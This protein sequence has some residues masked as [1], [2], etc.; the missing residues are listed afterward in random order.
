MATVTNTIKLPDGSTPDR[1]DVVIELVA[2]TTGRAAGW[3]T[4]SDVTIEATVRPTV[5]NGAWTA[6]LT[7]NA[8][9]TPSG[10]VYKVTEY[11]D[12]TR[13]THYIEV[14]ADGGSVLD[15][16]VDPPASVASAALTSHINDATDVH[17]ASAIGVLDA[18]GNYA[19][20]DVESVLAEIADNLDA[21]NADL[22]SHYAALVWRPSSAPMLFPVASSESP[23]VGA[24]ATSSAIGSAKQWRAVSPS[25]A[26]TGTALALPAHFTDR[27]GNGAWV[28]YGNS[29]PNYNYVTV[30]NV[31]DPVVGGY[32][33]LFSVEFET[34]ALQ[35]EFFV[36]G[37]S[38]KVWVW[39]DDRPLGGRTAT[40]TLTSSG[41]LAFLPLTFASRAR[42]RIRFESTGHLFGGVYTDPTATVQ[43]TSNFRPT[44]VMLGDSFT[45]SGGADV[46]ELSGLARTMGELLGWDVMPS[47]NG[48]TGY[49]NPGTG[50]RV[51]FRDRV[52]YDVIAKS[53]DIVVVAGGVND[54]SA[55]SAAAIGAEATA[56]FA[57]IAAGLPSAR[58]VVS[59]PF[60]RNGV[61]TIPYTL[62]DAKDAIYAAAA[63]MDAL[64]VDPI[65]IPL[66]AGQSLSST[67]SSATL[68]NATSF[69]SSADFPIG[70]TVEIG[71]STARERR[72]VTALSGVGPF[73]H[74]VAALNSAHPSGE[75]VRLVGPC[76]WT[77]TGKVGSTTGSGNSDRL[78]SSDGTHP[79]Q[80]GYDALASC[81]AAQIC[82]NW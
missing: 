26:A 66:R 69:A 72:V 38:G 80:D 36:K 71:T 63:A 8:D 77:G 79:T 60:W 24:V 35:M 41:S 11:V 33:G 15:L 70:C 61:E 57:A 56:L 40:W 74:T 19:G 7:P 1:V 53:P 47:G 58:L 23:T 81:L 16:L 9:I 4:A 6:S 18:A 42:R 30:A 14:D 29:Y 12:K 73:T 13:Y 76:L 46:A 62:L 10:S 50:G 2:S 5:T 25:V 51:K 65:E 55:Y 82:N 20:S 75:V 17:D 45:E 44:A 48:G 43:A 34:D 22:D 68:V 37:L 31:T 27:Q 28:K 67:L 54:Y 21:H 64:W 49:L 52:A 78:V 59:A 3:I 39:I 32:Q